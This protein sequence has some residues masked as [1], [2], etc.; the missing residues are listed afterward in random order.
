M[1]ES[2]ITQQLLAVLKEVIFVVYAYLIAVVYVIMLSDVC[3]VEG[4]GVLQ[5]LQEKGC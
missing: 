4:M 3:K 2:V 1:R 5:F